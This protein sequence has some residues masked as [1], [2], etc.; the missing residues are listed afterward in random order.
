MRRRLS[1][2][3]GTATRCER[4]RIRADDYGRRA[5]VTCASGTPADAHGRV[6]VAGG[7]GVAGSNPVSPIVKPQV[8]GGSS[9]IGRPVFCALDTWSR[10]LSRLDWSAGPKAAGRPANRGDS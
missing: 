4:P 10:G 6:L 5:L 8:R 7:Q 2:A 9:G 3:T 1:T